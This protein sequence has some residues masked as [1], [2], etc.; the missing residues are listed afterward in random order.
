MG[1]GGGWHARALKMPFDVIAWIML[2]CAWRKYPGCRAFIYVVKRAPRSLIIIITKQTHSLAV[3]SFFFS[4]FLMGTF[5]IESLKII[6]KM[7][8]QFFLSQPHIQKF[9]RWRIV[10][11]LMCFLRFC[12]FRIQ[13]IIIWNDDA[14]HGKK[15]VKNQSS[16]FHLPSAI[17]S[18]YLSRW[19]SSINVWLF[20]FFK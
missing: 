7:N 9:L 2:R 8:L 4:P 11:Q 16:L 19:S 14:F 5:I 15:K 17:L 12:S 1:G 3:Q 18:I 6:I 13:Y 10:L 20:F